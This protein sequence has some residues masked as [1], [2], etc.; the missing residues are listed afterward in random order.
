MSERED[1]PAAQD[2]ADYQ[3]PC[4]NW[5]VPGKERR[6]VCHKYGYPGCEEIAYCSDDCLAED[7]PEC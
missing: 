2:M 7:H 6:C 1:Y 5:C 3:C 4:G